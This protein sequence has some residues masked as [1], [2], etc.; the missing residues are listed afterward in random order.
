[1]SSPNGNRRDMSD[2]YIYDMID[3]KCQASTFVNR[4]HEMNT[5]IQKHSPNETGKQHKHTNKRMNKKKTSLKHIYF[6]IKHD[7]GARQNMINKMRIE[8]QRLNILT[9]TVCTVGSCGKYAI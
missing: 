4:F 6:H 8:L 7:A 2:I 5:T 3:L 9:G 1:M